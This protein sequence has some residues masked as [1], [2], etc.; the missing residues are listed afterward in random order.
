MYDEQFDIN[1]DKL[2][3]TQISESCNDSILDPKLESQVPLE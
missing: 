2:T 3:N 1:T